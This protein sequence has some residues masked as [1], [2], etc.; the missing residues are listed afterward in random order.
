VAGRPSGVHPDP[1]A[2]P[3]QSCGVVCSGESPAATI[4]VSVLCL[5]RR[6]APSAPHLCVAAWRFPRRVECQ[7]GG[8]EV[9]RLDP[10]YLTGSMTCSYGVPAHLSTGLSRRLGLCRL[11]ASLPVA[12]SAI[13]RDT[14]RSGSGDLTRWSERGGS[15]RC[16][17]SFGIAAP[18]TQD[19]S[20][21]PHSALAARQERLATPPNART[22]HGM[23]VLAWL[24]AALRDRHAR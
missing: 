8:R 2:P 16:C 15:L 12:C 9:E 21:Q 18:P 24:I 7:P 17:H 13:A 20:R 22:A 5:R 10:R 19:D 1:A 11:A 3:L 4:T 23:S 6:R 14:N